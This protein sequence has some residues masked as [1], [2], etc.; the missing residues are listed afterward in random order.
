MD[1]PI[2]HLDLFGNRLLIAV[3][4]TLHVLINHALAVGLIPLI[5]LLEYLGFRQR[6]TNPEL[7]RQWDGLAR[8]IMVT[9]F[10]ITTSLGALTGVGIWFSASLVNPAA[11]GSLIRVFFSAWFAEWVIFLL[12]VV[13]IMA[14]VL[15]W[16]K[17]GTSLPAKR[18]HIKAGAVLSIFSWLTLVIIAAILS[19]MMDPGN[20]ENRRTFFSGFFNPL[21][22]PQL[23]FRTPLAMILAGS[24]T[25]LSIPFFTQKGTEIRSRTVSF[26][27]LWLL[28]WLPVALVG[29]LFYREAIPRAMIGNLPTA[30]A[31]MA[32]SQWYD[33][34]LLVICGAILMAMLIAGW[35]FLKPARLPAWLLIFPLLASFVFTGMFERAR[36][37]IR[38]PYVIGNY[39]YANGLL[40]KDYP[41]YRETGVL[42]HAVYVDTPQVTA[43][44]RLKAG[45]NVFMIACSRCH[46]V[47]G[48]NSVARKYRNLATKGQPLDAE[49]MKTYTRQM[50]NV[51]Y[52]MPPFPGNGAELDALVAF[53]IEAE[54]NPPALPGAQTEGVVISPLHTL[55]AWP[56]NQPDKGERP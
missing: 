40:V 31:T 1:F 52:Y 49:A 32:F 23:Y 20:W 10:I 53:I 27:S 14:Y 25:L 7:A 36:E 45:Q 50:H 33:S 30:V 9:A 26:C 47:D 34:L 3:I 6:T 28:V 38:K 22:V 37:F 41:L 48:I 12:E 43:E 4:A 24:F 46:T 16:K 2:F 54:K 55:E 42:P 21:Y 35:G 39:M 8:K 11:I 29:A 51:R 56:K 13:F 17:S 15:T 19:F 18:R 5:T 44:N